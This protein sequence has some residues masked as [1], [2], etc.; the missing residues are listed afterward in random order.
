MIGY[1]YW[2]EIMPIV[3]FVYSVTHKHC[4]RVK[5]PKLKEILSIMGKD[6]IYP[7]NKKRYRS[8]DVKEL[9]LVG[10]YCKL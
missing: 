9:S 6:G 8:I 2:N 5:Y 3:V 4:Y 10:E 1:D 7:D